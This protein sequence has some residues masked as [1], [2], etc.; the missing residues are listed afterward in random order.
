M[1]ESFELGEGDY[2]QRIFQLLS[3]SVRIEVLTN[4]AF[5]TNVEQPNSK[6]VLVYIAKWTL[7]QEFITEKMGTEEM[8]KP[9]T[10]VLHLTIDQVD[11]FLIATQTLARFRNDLL[12]DLDNSKNFG[13]LTELFMAAFISL[14]CF[15]I[16][17]ANIGVPLGQMRIEE[18]LLKLTELE[19]Q[20][21]AHQN[22]KMN[23][24]HLGGSFDFDEVLEKEDDDSNPMKGKKFL[25]VILT[26]K[27]KGKKF[28][29]ILEQSLEDIAAAHTLL[30]SRLNNVFVDLEHLADLEV[31][32]RCYDESNRLKFLATRVKEAIEADNMQISEG[33]N[34]FRRL[35]NMQ[36][37]VLAS[38]FVLSSLTEAEEFARSVGK[39]TGKHGAHSVNQMALEI[40]SRINRL[41]KLLMPVHLLQTDEKRDCEINEMY[42][43]HKPF[44]DGVNIFGIACSAHNVPVFQHICLSWLR[45]EDKLAT[46]PSKDESH[47][48]G[49]HRGRRVKVNPHHE[50]VDWEEYWKPAM[51]RKAG[52]TA[53]ELKDGGYHAGDLKA[54][55]YTLFELLACGDIPLSELRA[56]GYSALEMEAT[57]F[58]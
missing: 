18:G 35:E 39:V 29:N 24:Q 12:S 23:R 34:S 6:D 45:I 47:R 31:E 1:F 38:S 28:L 40:E 58:R 13:D 7:A 25:D 44:P 46:K 53:R 56:A 4:L 17:T 3:A 10:D 55:G 27:F 43:M 42:I 30:I 16:T 33:G 36:S 19:Q 50:S 14:K 5:P 37:L 15:Q 9:L 22:V 2:I 26:A 41:R 51:L 21:K 20:F 57:G 8:K 54:A 49:D 48:G 11:Q 52:F 32:K